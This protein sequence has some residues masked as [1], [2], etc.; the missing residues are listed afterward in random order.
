ML[1]YA[2]IIN[3]ETKEVCVGMGTDEEYYKSIGMTE[4]EVEQAYNRYWYLKGYTPQ[5]PLNELKLAKR[6]EINQARDEAEQGGFE[7]LGKT[8]DSDQVSAQRISMACQALSNAP[9]EQT[10]TWTC[11][12]NTTI[13]LNGE[14]LQGLVV[15]LA[16]WSNECHQ[17][18][19]ALKIQIDTCESKEELDKIIWE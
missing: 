8:F 1:K 17:K 19:S 9:A 7:Y 18:A 2:K 13:D 6:E 3:E 11:Q 15:A 5:K 4:Q 12:D 16:T 10:I 14:Q